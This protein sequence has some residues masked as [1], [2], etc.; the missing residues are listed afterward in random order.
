[1]CEGAIKFF[2]KLDI[3]F[4]DIGDYLGITRIIVLFILLLV[5][6]VSTFDCS[7]S[8]SLDFVSNWSNICCHRLRLHVAGTDAV[9]STYANDP[10]E[11]PEVQVFAAAGPTSG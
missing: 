10:I 11:C 7:Y 5:A 9:T 4:L 3:G 6:S 2:K 8:F 1:M